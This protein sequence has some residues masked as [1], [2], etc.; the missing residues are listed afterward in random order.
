M[1]KGT[2]LTIVSLSYMTVEALHAVEELNKHGISCD[3][4]DLR[5]TSPLDWEKVFKSINKTGRLL[6]LDSSSGSFSVASE[7]IAKVAMN[8]HKDLKSPPKR[9]ALSDIPSPTSF[10]L[11]KKYYIG[12]KEI[13][14]LALE[15]LNKP[16]FD[17][18]SKFLKDHPHD[19]PGNW[20]KGPF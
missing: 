8:C 15:M 2:D 13:F 12:A 17:T 14:E 10:G 4:L 1:K 3:L 5:T 16:Q 6:A 7:V 11:S 18:T 20:F 9:L 19:V